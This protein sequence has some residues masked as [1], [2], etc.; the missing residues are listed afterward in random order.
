MKHYKHYI[1]L[2]IYDTFHINK[3]AISLLLDKKNKKP[4]DF[5]SF[6]NILI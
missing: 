4:Y 3:S 2:A 6:L 1:I 5:L